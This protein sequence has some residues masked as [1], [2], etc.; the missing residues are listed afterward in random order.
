MP[1]SPAQSVLRNLAPL[2]AIATLSLASRAQ[3][4]GFRQ[5]QTDDYTRYE[6]EAPGSAAF[7]I[8]YDV[9]ATAAGARYYFNAIR[10]GA[11][12]EVHG[13]TDLATGK[14]LEWRVVTGAEAR[15]VGMQNA[16]ANGRYI[17]ITLARPVPDGG[18]GRVRIDKTYRDTA[19]YFV[20]G[21]RLVFDRSLGITRNAVILPAGYEL[22]RVNYPSQVAEEEGGRIRVSFMNRG[23]SAVPYRVEAAKTGKEG[24]GSGARARGTR[25]GEGGAGAGRGTEVAHTAEVA[26][27]ADVAGTPQVATS[28]GGQAAQSAREAESSAAPQTAQQEGARVNYRFGER[29]F[30]DRDITYFLQQPGTHSFSLYHD[31][32]EKRVGMDRYVNVVRAGS[33]SSN[34]SAI[35]LDT[36]AK[37]KVE[38]L[39]GSE[40]TARGVDAE[41]PVTAET[42]VVAIWFD[43][44]PAGGSVRLRIS[45]TYTD[46]GRYVLVG[47]EL[48]WD[49]SFGRARN[50][51]VLPDGWYL[52]ANAV[53]A[54]IDRTDDG[55][56]RLRYVNDRPGD[57]DVFIR[58]RH[59]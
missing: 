44:V 56:I 26:R 4:Q 7:H 18:Q 48:V 3:A 6:L 32:T 19:S 36:G 57:I 38:T 5:T 37:L 30:E 9:S 55:R 20:E 14:A 10:E 15:A 23:P 49:R 13:V 43:P 27:V 17:Q 50:T 8:I 25:A 35:D 47:N 33:R 11:E 34:P 54:V 1:T 16:G 29:A 53:P 24:I 46:P 59:R 2:L 22:V 41:G 12:E 42:E 28:G 51:V 21:D 58:A 45:E 40:I 31:Y 39:R 52:T